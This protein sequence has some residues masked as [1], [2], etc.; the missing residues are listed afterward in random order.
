MLIQDHVTVFQWLLCIKYG[1]PGLA[2]WV[3]LQH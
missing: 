1:G 3:T 2:R